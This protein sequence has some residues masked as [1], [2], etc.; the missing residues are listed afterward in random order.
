MAA[1]TPQEIARV[2][3]STEQAQLAIAFVNS[4][5]MEVRQITGTRYKYV[6]S[7]QPDPRDRK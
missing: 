2:I 5:D 7:D 1:P 3:T 4:L 6:F